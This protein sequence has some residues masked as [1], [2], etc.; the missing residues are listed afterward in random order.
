[1]GSALFAS[2]RGNVDWDGAMVLSTIPS[3]ARRVPLV[4]HN[5]FMDLSF[6]M[7]HLHGEIPSDYSDMKVLLRSQFPIIFDTKTMSI[8]SPYGLNLKADATSSSLQNAFDALVSEKGEDG[9][10]FINLLR[11]CRKDAESDQ[12]QHEA[13]YDAYLTGGVFAAMLHRASLR[14]SKTNWIEVICDP[15]STCARSQLKRN[16]LHQMSMFNCDLE[17]PDPYLDPMKH[18]VAVESTFRVEGIDKSTG[19]RD[20]VRNLLGMSDAQG[21][22]VNYEIIWVDDATFMVAACV[23]DIDPFLDIGPILREHGEIVYGRLKSV[24][25]RQKILP[26]LTYFT[27]QQQSGGSWIGGVLAALGFGKKRSFDGMESPKNGRK[28]VRRC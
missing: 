2:E 3:S 4:V 19:T 22:V 17:S 10:A 18:G 9:E 21:R 25:R 16:V 24:F 14:D 13:A 12:N 26:L 23:K 1:L 5:G 28:Q 15:S 11:F 20:I 27:Q 7:S 8:E 6:L